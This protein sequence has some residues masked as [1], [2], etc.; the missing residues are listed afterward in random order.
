MVQLVEWVRCPSLFEMDKPTLLILGVQL[1]SEG[2]P[3]VLHRVAAL[4]RSEQFSVSKIHYP[5]WASTTQSSSGLGRL[6]RNFWRMLAAHCAALFGYLRHPRTDCIYV[7]Y[8][9]TIL[10]WLMSFLP[11]RSNRVVVDTFISLYDTV[12]LDRG[13]LREGGLVARLL[14]LLERRALRSATI[15][16]VDTPLSAA[17]LCE[18]F[19]LPAEQVLAI[20]LSTN[21]ETF[22]PVPTGAVSQRCRVL[23]VGTLIPLHGV[24]TITAAAALLSS[25]KDIDITV[26][27]D[28][29]EAGLVEQAL[30]ASAGCLGWQRQWM[31]SEEMA[32]AIAAADICLGIFGATE[33]AGRVLP[34]KLYAYTRIG[35]CIITAATECTASLT[36][37]LDYRPWH[38]VPAADPHALA[39]AIIELTEAPALR[40]EFADNAARFYRERLSNAAAQQRLEAVLLATA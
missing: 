9:G 21:E 23:F 27:G 29:Q 24:Q 28:G 22:V 8:P 6:L 20:P 12:V 17:Y 11:R 39:E 15:N 35:R 34:F 26:V 36:A 19:G 10:L 7:P 18:L 13:L 32:E 37:D 2:Y 30:L 4:Q 31:S 25:R 33:K 38:E 16:I 14:F 40:A 5:A 3:N 1:E